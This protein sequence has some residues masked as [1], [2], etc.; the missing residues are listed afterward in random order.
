VIA[1]TILACL[2]FVGNAAASQGEYWGDYTTP[3]NI[4][5]LPRFSSGILSV[6]ASGREISGSLDIG[7]PFLGDPTSSNER[8]VQAWLRN[9]QC[10]VRRVEFFREPVQAGGSFQAERLLLN[11]ER[12]HPQRSIVTGWFDGFSQSVLVAVARVEPFGGTRC[13]SK[14]Q[15]VFAVRG[16]SL[17]FAGPFAD[18][19][20]PSVRGQLLS[21]VSGD[22]LG[23]IAIEGVPA[24]PTR[25]R[26]AYVRRFAARAVVGDCRYEHVLQEND[27]L[28]RKLTPVSRDG[29]WLPALGAELG[30]FSI[31][32][33]LSESSIRGAITFDGSAACPSLTATFAAEATAL[34]D[35]DFLG[36]PIVQATTQNL[37]S[38]A[39]LLLTAPVGVF[40]RVPEFAPPEWRV[41]V[42]F[43]GGTASDLEAA[44]LAQYAR[45]VSAQDEAGAWRSF[46]V[47]M[48]LANPGR[49]E[50][51]SYFRN[52]IPRGARVILSRNIS[53]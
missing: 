44:A 16:D 29:A 27:P 18:F 17:S 36:T 22:V 4:A 8:D 31:V 23:Q 6:E 52:G 11:A 12:K 48:G 19:T 37:V 2:L 38:D 28:L 3:K 1:A 9:S 35:D 30:T 34:S 10:H 13:E 41:E 14:E 21:S 24:P 42:I 46:A 51:T 20:V 39:E 5:T 25:P 40:I 49:E 47:G 43:S 53:P 32:G 7:S 15:L 26:Q 50:F 33:A 45:F